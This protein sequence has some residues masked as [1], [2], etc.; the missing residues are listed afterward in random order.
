MF[1]YTVTISPV[2]LVR[3][4]PVIYLPLSTWDPQYTSIYPQHSSTSTCTFHLQTLMFT[5]LNTAC[6]LN[7]PTLYHQSP[8]ASVHALVHYDPNKNAL[9]GL[10]VAIRVIVN[11]CIKWLVRFNVFHLKYA[12]HRQW[13]MTWNTSNNKIMEKELFSRNFG[14]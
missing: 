4:I 14:K 13:C 11:K 1:L 7:D 2:E 8:C 3:I 6:A 12:T 9:H 5:H 10:I